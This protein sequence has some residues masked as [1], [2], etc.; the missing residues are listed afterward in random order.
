MRVYYEVAIRS[1]RRAT[2]YRSAY[3]AG[4]LTNAFFGALMSL[5]FI[6]VYGSGGPVA[7]LTLRD[8]LSYTW[9]TQSLISIG[10]GW[11]IMPEISLTRPWSFYGYWLARWLGEAGLNLL[12]RGS[13]TYL[14]GV[15]YFDAL[16][17][18][19]DALPW[20]AASI[21]L[22][23]LL[24]FAISF[25]VHLTAFWLVENTGVIMITNVLLNFFSGFTLPI[26]FFPPL[27][28]TIANLLPFRA[29]TGLPAQIFLSQLPAGE[30]LPTLAIQL[31]WTVLLIL[32][33]LWMQHAAMRKV[34]VQGG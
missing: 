1:F 20:F 34:V 30:R 7:G 6:A 21:S 26:A 32:F 28:A 8:A 12:L 18:N 19:P 11:T 25:C 5:I 33:G 27:L 16:L 9:A 23:L 15:L 29:V 2:T 3:V 17:P 31:G 14:I 10:G 13:L 4:I 22:A 24:S